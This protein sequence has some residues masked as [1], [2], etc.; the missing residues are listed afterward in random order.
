V[1]EVAVGEGD[2]AGEDG[3]AGAAVEDIVTVRPSRLKLAITGIEALTVSTA[4][5]LPSL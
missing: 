3:A 2:A 1:D 5:P 4:A